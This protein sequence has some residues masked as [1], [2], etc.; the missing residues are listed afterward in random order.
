[1]LLSS[2]ISQELDKS[3]KLTE[4]FDSSYISLVRGLI[5]PPSSGGKTTDLGNDLDSR[6]KD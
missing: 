4:S 1:M 6:Q 5:D 3:S 2:R